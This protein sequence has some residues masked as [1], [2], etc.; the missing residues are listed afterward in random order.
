[1]ILSSSEWL[2]DDLLRRRRVD[3]AL[4]VDAARD[5]RRVEP[6]LTVD[7]VDGE[8]PPLRI[9]VA[10]HDEDAVEGVRTGQALRVERSK[11]ERV[12]VPLVLARAL[13]RGRELIVALHAHDDDR[14]G[15][16]DSDVLR[17]GIDVHDDRTR[18]TFVHAAGADGHRLRTRLIAVCTYRQRSTESD[19]GSLHR[20]RS[21]R[22][23]R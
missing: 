2:D 19:R 17:R 20:I 6:P 10:R 7:G 14:V 18:R 12:H 13:D 22:A 11:A 5:V 3:A 8:P 21:A 4:A 23:F 16:V 15:A 1:M 9:E